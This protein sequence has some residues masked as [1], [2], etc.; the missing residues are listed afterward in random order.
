MY[1][2][3]TRGFD[4]IY[5]PTDGMSSGAHL[6]KDTKRQLQIA[7]QLQKLFVAARRSGIDTL[8]R[9]FGVGLCGE[10]FY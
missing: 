7:F 9:I 3:F 6:R 2:P 5:I 10:S 4:I 1:I 8:S